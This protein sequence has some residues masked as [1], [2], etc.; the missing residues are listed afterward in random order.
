MSESNTP[1]RGEVSEVTSFDAEESGAPITDGDA[2]AGNPDF[3]SGSA[4]EPEP[5]AGP[6]GNPHRD[7]DTH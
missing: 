1:S 7:K 2:I 6:N 5:E 3:E 4:Q